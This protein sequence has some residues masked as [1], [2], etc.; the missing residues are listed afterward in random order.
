MYDSNIPSGLEYLLLDFIKGL[1]K[2]CK[3]DI[4][5]CYTSCNDS[6]EYRCDGAVRHNA[7]YGSST[8]MDLG[9]ACDNHYYWSIFRKEQVPKTRLL[10]NL[11]GKFYKNDSDIKITT[12]ANI[13]NG[14]SVCIHNG[15]NIKDKLIVAIY[16]PLI[17]EGLTDCLQKYVDT[18]KN[19]REITF[20]NMS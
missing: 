11:F 4:G 18:H 6:D 12:L 14:A 8:I 9:N 17:R 1:N 3:N 19:F 15:E 7:N 13:T 10:K 5:L 16:D 20:F 2:D